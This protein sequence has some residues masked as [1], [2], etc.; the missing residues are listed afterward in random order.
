MG[1][2]I[3]NTQTGKMV[4]K[5]PEKVSVCES[6]G[7]L[8]GHHM[9]KEIL[10]QQDTIRKAA[11]QDEGILIETAMDILRAKNVVF[12]ACGTARYAAIV[13]RY[14]FSKVAKKFS[15][16]IMAHEFQYFLDAVDSNTVVIAVS[17]SGE[18]ADVLE[19][20]MKAK[21]KGT[22][23]VSITNVP[24]SSLA[25]ISDRVFD[26]KC[27]PEIAVAS[28]KA[29]TGQLAVLYRI[30]FATITRSYDAK[31][32]LEDIASKVGRMVCD[33]ND[34]IEDLANKIKD[35]DDLYYLGRGIDFAI[36]SEGALKLKE[37][38]YQHAEG[39]PAGELKHGTLSLISKGTPVVAIAPKDYTFEETLNNA[40]EAKARGAFIIGVS[41]VKKSMFD[42]WIP[43]PAVKEVFYP[44]VAVIPLQ[45]LAYYAAVARGNNPDKPRNLAK[46][47]T[48]K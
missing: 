15:E 16:V 3:Y 36:A 44:M 45:M 39:M 29:F 17:Q 2:S 12:V 37:L 10:E 35:K 31:S 9:L 42:V 1:I 47:V 14:L 22:K 18:T 8:E 41:D 43:I 20:V 4:K 46:S 23:L 33:L 7:P 11:D 25:R 30:A 27:G 28:T 40:N 48:V 24:T 21:E 13:G 19:G 32:E 6:L 38:S 5:K 34:T 26:I